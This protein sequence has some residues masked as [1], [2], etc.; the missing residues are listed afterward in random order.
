MTSPEGAKDL[1][2]DMP[3]QE[4]CPTECPSIS[5]GATEE[6]P[7]S[8]VVVDA[9]VCIGPDERCRH[10]VIDDRSGIDQQ[11]HPGVGGTDTPV[12]VLKVEEVPFV[13]WAHP[14]YHQL[15]VTCV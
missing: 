3:T 12:R 8:R 10:T 11:G 9:K 6:K 13:E 5:S 7:I 1:R 15:K 2:K 14:Q 4:S